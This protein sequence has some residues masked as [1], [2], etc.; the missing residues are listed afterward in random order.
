[1]ITGVQVTVRYVSKNVRHYTY[2]LDT[3][4]I[5]IEIVEPFGRR[6]QHQTT[7]V[8]LSRRRTWHSVQSESQIGLTIFAIGEFPI[9]RQLRQSKF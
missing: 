2:V 8:L 7:G 1:L 3:I 5:Y 6:N 9:S 4:Y